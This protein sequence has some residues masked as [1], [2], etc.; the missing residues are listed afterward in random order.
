VTSSNAVSLATSYTLA[1]ASSAREVSRLPSH[2]HSTHPVDETGCTR[3]I[4]LRELGAGVAPANT[5]TG[6]QP[7]P[8]TTQR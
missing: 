8:E 1:A 3:R 2:R 5:L 7:L 4:Q 6:R